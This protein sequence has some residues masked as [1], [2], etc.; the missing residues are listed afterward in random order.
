[1]TPTGFMTEE[2]WVELAPKMADGIRSM[3]VI[4]QNP[5]WWVLKIV[6][7]FGPHVSS[8]KAMEIYASRKILLLKEE[9]DASHVNQ[10]YDQE[11]AKKD[12][13]SMRQSLAHLRT[14]STITKNVVDGWSLIHVGLACVRELDK[15]SWVRSFQ[16][17]NLHPHHRLPFPEWCAKIRQFLEGGANFNEETILDPYTLLP[18]WWHGMLPAEKER[19]MALW[20][21]C[22]H[23]FSVLFVKK[24]HAELNI[25]LSEMQN[26]R[27]CLEL[28]REHP[29]HLSKGIPETMSGPNREQA[30]VAAVR[31]ALPDVAN[32]LVS[33]Q[34]HP[35]RNDGAQLY[36][37]LE[38]LN[39]LSKLARRSVPT[40]KKLAPSAYLDV[41]MTSVQQRLLDPSAQD[42]AMHE[43]AR[44]AHGDGAKQALAKRKLDAIGNVRGHSGFANDEA[45]C[46]RLKNQLNLVASLAEIAKEAENDKA[47]KK[48]Q[49]MSEMVNSAPAAIAKLKRH[50]A[51]V[52]KL[53]IEEMKSIAHTHFGGA[54]LSGVKSAHAIA[55]QKLIDA[56]PSILSAL[57]AAAAPAIPT[58][59]AGDRARGQQPKRKPR[60]GVAAA[61]DDERGGESEGDEE[62]DSISEEGEEEGDEEGD[63]EGG[64]EEG[65]EE[66][67]E[68]EQVDEPQPAGAR[69][70]FAYFH[71]I[72]SQSVQMDKHASAPLTFDV[73]LSYR[74][75]TAAMKNNLGLHEHNQL[76][77]MMGSQWVWKSTSPT[78]SSR[79][80]LAQI[81]AIG[82][83]RP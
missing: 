7:G 12:K 59:N 27:I 63:E 77:L 47:T 56:Q 61:D 75:L 26:L 17:V 30:E 32:G 71:F 33:F 82:L 45:R 35:K 54:V 18:S 4:K 20:T 16:K 55:L 73:L 36:K 70:V 62:E 41:E 52:A 8:V 43:I 67:D 60:N 37:G 53:T 34:L 1:M 48:S 9:G 74:W 21:S 22:E 46:Q 6:D 3:D 69:Q 42:Y 24:A 83:E 25:P 28:A 40:S 80:S 19:S 49:R 2:A 58:I 29:E 57:L 65:E 23:D 15:D 38:K 14:I 39:H 81:K 11:V 79:M 31:A 13:V 64:D 10:A 44:H 76:E 72:S 51:D 78:M 66:G 68:E 50:G 5:N